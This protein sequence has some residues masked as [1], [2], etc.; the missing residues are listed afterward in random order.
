MEAAELAKAK[1]AASQGKTLARN[2][3]ARE[4]RMR[5]NPAARKELAQDYAAVNEKERRRAGS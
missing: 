2:R 3:R 4:R 1:A 5:G